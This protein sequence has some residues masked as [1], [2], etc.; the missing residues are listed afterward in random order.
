MTLQDLHRHGFDRSSAVFGIPTRLAVAC[1]QCEALVIN[2][3][4][5]HERGCPHEGYRCDE[6]GGFYLNQM[7]A[8]TCCAE[9]DSWFTRS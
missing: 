5:T 4:P 9:E 3:I 2:G 8:R 1:S 6:C 7:D